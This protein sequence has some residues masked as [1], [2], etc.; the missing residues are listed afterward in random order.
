MLCAH[1]TPQQYSE[2]L[3]RQAQHIYLLFMLAWI[4]TAFQHYILS[5]AP[6]GEDVTFGV[7][8]PD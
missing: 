6:P 3:S 2:G 1:S 4:G 8:K 5:V 7:H